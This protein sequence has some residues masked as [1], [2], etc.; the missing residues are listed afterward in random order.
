M[1]I[2]AA[3]EES[4]YVA[5][6][7]IS[8]ERDVKRDAFVAGGTVRVSGDIGDDLRIAGGTVTI[9]G[10]IA[11]DLIISGGT[12]RLLPEAVIMGDALISGGTVELYGEIRGAT[13]LRAATVALGATLD[14][15]DIDVG[16]LFVEDGAEITGDLVYRSRHLDE[17]E[18]ITVGESRYIASGA[19]I[20]EH[21]VDTAW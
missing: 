1:T 10:D 20:R 15:L 5:G 8:I 6:G 3:I 2:D 21:A 16:S 13:K 14:S 11:G 12:I 18:A 17:L 4:L 7:D 9:G 19:S